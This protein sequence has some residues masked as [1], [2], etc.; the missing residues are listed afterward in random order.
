MRHA[1]TAI[2]LLTAL[3]S[4]PVFARAQAADA[5]QPAVAQDCRRDLAER[6]GL[7]V[8]DVSVVDVRSTT[9]PDAALGLPEPGHLYAQVLT[10]GWSLLLEVRSI[11]YLYTAGERAFRYGGP[12][13]LWQYSALYIEPVPN[14]PNF[15]GNVI[16]VSLVGTNPTL[17]LQS[18]NAFEPQRDGSVIATRRT[19]R[20]G[21]DLLYV[22]PGAVGESRKLAAGFSFGDSAVSPDGEQWSAFRR[23]FVGA[24]WTVSGNPIGADS[25]QMWSADLPEGARPLK[26][27][28]DRERPVAELEVAGEAGYYELRE[29][30]GDRTWHKLDLYAPPETA[31]MMLNKSETLVVTT[32]ALGEEPGTR[33]VRRWFTG[34]D[35]PVATLT[36]FQYRSFGVTPDLRFLLLSGTEDEAQVAYVVDIATGEV[37]PCVRGARGDAQ[38]LLAAPWA[39]SQLEELLGLE[40]EE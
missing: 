26:L 17:L 35:K 24:P 14:E 13:A 5:D 22:E 18:A 23:P 30:G 11:R 4:S 16:Q 2:L 20:S 3:V 40:E 31:D 34:D 15:N 7:S 28:Y 6:L 29:A 25:A 9:W 12:P 21:H 32:E 36:G 19:S 8:D 10:P 39:W 1:L 38:L 37:L 27:F 33:V